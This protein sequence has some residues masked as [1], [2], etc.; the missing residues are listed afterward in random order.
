MRPVSRRS[1]VPGGATGTEDVVVT[2][3]KAMGE[4]ALAQIKPD[5]FGRAQ[6]GCI[7]GQ[8]SRIRLAGMARSRAMCQP[9]G[10]M[11]TTAWALRLTASASSSRIACMAAALTLGKTR[12]T[13]ASRRGRPRQQVDCLVAQVVHAAWAHGA[14]EPAAADAA[15]PAD[16]GGPAALAPAGAH[17]ACSPQRPAQ[18]RRSAILAVGKNVGAWHPAAAAAPSIG[19]W[20]AIRASLCGQGVLLALRRRQQVSGRSFRP[21]CRRPGTSRPPGRRRSA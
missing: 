9:A 21:G 20:S 10:S 17:R 18:P 3:P 13:P 12:T 6:L 15:G 4:Q 8:E 16:P 11:R 2:G 5:P 14:L 1:G 7:R 19:I